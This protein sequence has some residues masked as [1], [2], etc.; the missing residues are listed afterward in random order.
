MIDWLSDIE[1]Y[2]RNLKEK[3]CPEVSDEEFAK[4]FVVKFHLDSKHPYASI[5]F[6]TPEEL[7]EEYKK[8]IK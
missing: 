4:L 7:L 6:K 5:R 2:L 8:N 3:E 1:S